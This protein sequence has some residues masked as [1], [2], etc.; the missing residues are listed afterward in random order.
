[1]SNRSF[2]NVRFP[3]CSLSDRVTVPGQ[4]EDLLAAVRCCPVCLPAPGRDLAALA[5]CTELHSALLPKDS[6][7]SAAGSQ[8]AGSSPGPKAPLCIK[9]I[10]SLHLEYCRV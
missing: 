7:V 6:E 10:P 3:V 2:S 5:A 1:M 9:S 8:P 4:K